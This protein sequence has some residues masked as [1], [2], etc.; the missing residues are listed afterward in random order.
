MPRRDSVGGERFHGFDVRPPRERW[1][2]AGIAT[3]FVTAALTVTSGA[4]LI[5]FGPRTYTRGTGQPVAVT[6]TFS[7]AQPSGTYMLRVV[8]QGVTSAVISLNGTPIL[9]PEDFPSASLVRAVT[10][11][12]GA[13]ELAV[14]LRGAPKTSLT[15]EIVDT[16]PQDTVP[17]V[18]TTSIDP[19]PDANG[20]NNTSVTVTFTCA[21]SGSGVATCPSP[22]MMA[23]ADGD[24]I[25]SGTAVDT[26]GNTATASVTLKVDLTPPVVSVLAS[27]A[28]N[29][30]GWH[31]GP[32]IVSFS[33]ADAL[34]GVAPGSVTPTLTLSTDGAGLSATGQATDLAGNVGAVTLDGINVD[35][36]NPVLTFAL[37]PTPNAA[38]A[39]S[40]PVTVHFE[41]TDAG[42]GI[43]SC[44][45]DQVMATAGANPGV[46][47]TASDRAGNTASVTTAPFTI[48][49]GPPTITTSITPP[50]NANGWHDTPVTVHFTCTQNG[51]PLP[52]CPA[53]RVV[54]TEGAGQT[55]TGTVTNAA[56]T[57]ASV[58]TDP[59]SI[60]L[61]EPSLTVAISP[62]P[63]TTGWI[64]SAVTAHFVCSDTGSGV[65]TCPA[66]RIIATEGASQTVTGTATD[67][68]GHTAQVTSAPFS[69]D[70]QPPTVVSTVTPA[71]NGNGWNNTPVTVQFT[72]SDTGSGVATCPLEQVI[73]AEGMNQAVTA[74]AMDVAGNSGTAAAAVNIDLTAPVLVFA[75]LPGAETVFTS[76]LAIT[77]SV[78]DAGSGILGVTCAGTPATVLQSQFR[79]DAALV[80]G[81]NSIAAIATDLAGNTITS[82][83]SMNYVR[84]PTVTITSPATLGYFNI[85]PTTVTGTVDE[86]TATVTVNGIAAPV[87]GGSFTIPLPLAEGPNIITATATTSTGAAATA[88]VEVTFD[89]NPP[90]VTITSPADGFT[91][92][93]D[94]ISIA[95]NVNDIVVGTV[96]DQQAQVSV[97]GAGAQVANRAFLAATVP[98]AMGLNTIQVV[99]RDRVGNAATTQ[100]SVI[101]QVVMQP[102]IRL[103]SGN[104]QTGVIGSLLS[105]PLVI[106]LSDGLGSTVPNKTVIFKVTQNDGTLT[107]GGDPGVTVLATTDGQGRAEGR[108]TLG[109]RAGAGSN[110]VEVYAVGFEGTAVFAASGTPGT[111]GKIVVDTGNDQIGAV[112]QGLPK[113]FIAVVVDNGNNRLAG[114][115]VTFT[116]QQGGGSFNGQPTMTATSDSDGRVAATLTLG[117]QEG[118]ANNLVEANF[119]FNTSFA[120]AFTASGRV[121]G[122]PA[123]TTIAGIVLD[124]SNEPIPGATVRAV[125]TNVVRS[126]L[127]AVQAALAV[128][129]DAQGQFTIPQAPVGLIKLMIDGTTAERDGT[130]P[131][132]EYDLV[133]VAGQKNDVGQPIYLLPLSTEN[134]L[135]VTPTTGGGTLTIPEAPGFSLTFGPGQVTFPGGTKEGCV[136]VTVVNGD[137]IPMVPGFGQQPRFIVTIQPAGAVFNPPAPITIPNVDGLIPRA[138]TEMYSFDHDIGSFVAIGTGIVSDDGQVIRSAPGVGVLKA[139][140]HCGGDPAANGT[141]ADC[142]DCKW[143]QGNECVKDPAQD[144]RACETASGIDGFCLNGQ[145]D[146][147]DC[148]KVVKELQDINQVADDPINGFITNQTC[149]ANSSCSGKAGLENPHW[150]DNVVKDFVDPF[151]AQTGDWKAVIAACR[152]RAWWLPFRDALCENDMARYHISQDLQNALNTNGCGT[153][154]DW[155]NI[156]G[157]ITKCISEGLDWYWPGVQTIAEWIADNLVEGA[158]DGVWQKCIDHRTTSGMPV[159]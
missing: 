28:A 145:C 15:V 131:S 25:V 21:D 20:W 24:Q 134:Q 59:F 46:T 114:V 19:P 156:G 10:L 77:G 73:S 31:N 87:A 159:F 17:P 76:V 34:S 126:N 82:S 149:I 65:A 103:I 101:R 148:P 58:T 37:S 115:D 92:A 158:R 18:I 91:T 124:N 63:G 48:H 96:N 128:Q 1:W 89:T 117:L 107:S 36:V 81:A 7:V 62:S 104:G 120:A 3:L 83:L 99:A 30:N 119:P 118:S 32:V 44:P 43:D 135:C 95:G 80:P 112:G 137:K 98:L 75:S 109:N 108:W 86:D 141:V 113:P 85:S 111:A 13:N 151:T 29:V 5:V 154:A 35:Q 60:D 132:L 11:R 147:G 106:E 40:G 38:G 78:S 127:S 125:L 110:I 71:P 138:V 53:D 84:Q 94:S 23:T 74:V 49:V 51:M 143:C 14:E 79:C 61:S 93:A 100:I 102:Q 129:T 67:A 4:D 139:G 121:P 26:S 153:P 130:Y 70:V 88:S 9:K 64:N 116:V 2:V 54:A 144:S 69:I 142:P 39:V 123:D 66:D 140:W 41:C 155:K 6:N 150:L 8:S 97:N 50:P 42:S 12:G 146:E 57:T 56:G 72:C 105:A 90:H 52:D 22:M 152:A 16:A 68:A 47:G 122:N 133:T 55:V 45:P 33:A 157:V 27:P 136:S